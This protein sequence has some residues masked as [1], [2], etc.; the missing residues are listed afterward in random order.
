MPTK[1]V[2]LG[3]LCA[4]LECEGSFCIWFGS[5]G[6]PAH[7]PDNEDRVDKV[8]RAYLARFIIEREAVRRGVSLKRVRADQRAAR[9]AHA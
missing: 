5:K 4:A 3:E 8:R 9:K 6:S 2:D 7:H 1:R